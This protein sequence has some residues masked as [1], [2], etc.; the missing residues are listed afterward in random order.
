M[1]AV[2]SIDATKH[3]PEII[4]HNIKI[5]DY[6]MIAPN[7]GHRKIFIVDFIHTDMIA[8]HPPSRPSQMK[9]LEPGGAPDE[10]ILTD[11]NT[12]E[13]FF[14]WSHDTKK[15]QNRP[16]YVEEIRVVWDDLP[17]QSIKF[18]SQEDTYWMDYRMIKEKV[19][20]YVKE[21]ESDTTKPL[22][23]YKIL[24][25]KS[26]KRHIP[27]YK[28]DILIKSRTK[29]GAMV[30]YMNWLDTQDIDDYDNYMW[31]QV[32]PIQFNV[33]YFSS[34]EDLV[35]ELCRSCMVMKKV[36][37]E[38]SIISFPGPQIDLIKPVRH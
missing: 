30:T 27:G 8:I 9:I 10:W 22:T 21:L 11:N 23:R 15:Y 32:N 14:D 20:E 2:A 17:I 12:N 13:S 5:G 38:P 18:L 33:K 29:Y 3:H 36:S 31:D 37:N 24:E 25:R 1:M 19:I 16:F 6:I 35:G 28:E 34:M 4:K 26:A 7:R